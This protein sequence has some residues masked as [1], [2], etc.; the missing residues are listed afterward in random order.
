VLYVE[1]R[2]SVYVL[3]FF[4]VFSQAR[5]DVQVNKRSADPILSAPPT[6]SRLKRFVMSDDS[7]L[8]FV[9]CIC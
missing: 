1:Q 7:D 2:K 4:C 5:V 3:A 6:K 8:R 9:I